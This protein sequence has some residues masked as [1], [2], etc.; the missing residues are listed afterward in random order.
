MWEDQL[1][2]AGHVITTERVEGRNRYG[3]KVH[4]ARYIM[5]GNA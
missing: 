5:G 2:R 1:K 3:E 4:Y